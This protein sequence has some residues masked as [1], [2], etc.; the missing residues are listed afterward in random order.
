[1]ETGIIR[2]IKIVLAAPRGKDISARREVSSGEETIGRRQVIY[3]NADITTNSW[4][5]IIPNGS[6]DDPLLLYNWYGIEDPD[7]III[8][9]LERYDSI[10][11]CKSCYCNP[12]SFDCIEVTSIAA[13]E[14]VLSGIANYCIGQVNLFSSKNLGNIL[15][16][17]DL[18][19]TDPKKT[20][21]SIINE[22][23]RAGNIY[24]PT[25][26]TIRPS[27]FTAGI[28]DT[29]SV[30]S[31]SSPAVSII[32]INLSDTIEELCLNDSTRTLFITVYPQLNQINEIEIAGLSKIQCC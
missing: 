26:G 25:Y 17:M 24:T 16:T 13:I 10:Y 22:Q 4:S 8:H 2:R 31:L 29:T 28:L 3:V 9:T 20:V 18:T 14:T 6:E 5:D 32:P 15:P 11:K 1:M 7:E 23:F 27:F 30:S 21:R 12:C 19:I